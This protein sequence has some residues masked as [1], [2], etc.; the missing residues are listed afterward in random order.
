MHA[1]C[2]MD[3]KY[4][5]DSSAQSSGQKEGGERTT[6]T[7][8]VPKSLLEQLPHVRHS[9]DCAVIHANA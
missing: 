7:A 8:T 6:I 2:F 1:V 4:L 5:L 3:P 9:Y